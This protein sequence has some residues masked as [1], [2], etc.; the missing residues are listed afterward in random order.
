[1][2]LLVEGS[3]E[4][5]VLV[6]AHGAGMA[7]DHCYLQQISEQLVNCGLMVVRFEF[8]YMAQRR[9]TGKRRLPDKMPVLEQCFLDVIEEVQQRYPELFSG[10][11]NPLFLA[12]KSMGGR[13]ATLIA[14]QVA[15]SAVFVY[16]YPFHSIKKPEVLRIEHLQQLR[17]EIHIFQGE[18]DKLGNKA[19]VLTYPL[20]ENV[21]LHWLIDGDHDL[22]PRVR[23][24]FTQLQHL[25]S[26]IN[27]VGR[28]VDAKMLSANCN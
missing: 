10:S 6:L 2:N 22:H 25:Q 20:S 4:K 7:M 17:C 15:A 9:G 23:S 11:K 12:G 19:E 5:G 28:I 14:D 21:Q 27:T 24:G 13:G 16:G 8:P 26:V 1:M 18:R 3:A